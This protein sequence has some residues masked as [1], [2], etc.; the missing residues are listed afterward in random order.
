MAQPFPVEILNYIN[1]GLSQKPR[2]FR[3]LSEHNNYVSPETTTEFYLGL[4]R[5]IKQEL[6]ENGAIRLP[7]IGDLVLVKQRARPGLIG[8]S[9]TIIPEIDVLKFIPNRAFYDSVRRKVTH[10]P[11]VP[12]TT[13]D[14]YGVE[15]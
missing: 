7:G 11:Y 6:R 5:L 13:L 4:T 14:E 3:L 15:E 1:R 8:N 10:K 12:N 9:H 2:F